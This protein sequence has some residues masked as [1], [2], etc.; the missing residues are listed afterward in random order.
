MKNEIKEGEAKDGAGRLDR[1]RNVSPS[2][3]DTKLWGL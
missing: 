3:K 1:E 2:Y